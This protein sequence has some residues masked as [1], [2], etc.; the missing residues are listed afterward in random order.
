MLS[1]LGPLGFSIAEI[2][3]ASAPLAAYFELV[4]SVNVTAAAV[5]VWITCWFGLRRRE[6][7]AW[8]ALAFS[9]LWV[10]GNDRFAAARYTIVTGIPFVVAPLTFCVLMAA[11]LG[12]TYCG[13]FRGRPT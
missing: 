4:G 13:V 5:Y 3:R 1:A 9:L 7:W 6:R 2:E 12:L 8:W 11:G 10:G